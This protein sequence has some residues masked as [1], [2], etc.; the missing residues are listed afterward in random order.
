MKP[1]KTGI[2]HKIWQIRVTGGALY[3][4]VFFMLFLSMF[5]LSLL[6][7]FELSFREDAYFIKK[8]EL[9]DNIASAAAIVSCYPERVPIG[10]V[11]GIDVFEDETAIVAVTSE[12]WGLLRKMTFENT[13][14]SIRNRKI[15]LMA[16]KEKVRPALWMPDNM[17]YASL[18]GNSSIRGD[19]YISGMGLRTGNIEGRY[20]EG[21]VLNEGE[22]YVSEP[23]MPAFNNE[24]FSY[25]TQY[26]KG[27]IPSSDSLVNSNI[28]KR[29]KDLK[30]YFTE[31]TL[32]IQ[33]SGK[34][35]LDEGS[36]SGNIIICSGDTIEIFPSIR[37][38]NVILMG[39]IIILHEGVNGKFQAFASKSIEVRK[40]CRLE[41]P[42]FLGVL[43]IEPGIEL[44][45]DENCIINGGVLCHSNA[46]DEEA[47]VLSIG[48]GSIIYGKAYVNGDLYLSGDIAGSLYCNRFAYKTFRAF[49]EN[50]ILDC[51][52][53]SEKL[54]K[55]YASFTF[56]DDV[57]KLREIQICL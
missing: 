55:D 12:R 29:E 18:V 46:Q 21:S 34:L 32:L 15:V 38:D 41:Y 9:D 56:T 42:S 23:E 31:K 47:A 53:D 14:R 50:F 49:Y 54:P 43:D 16:E 45:I 44:S 11:T 20:F 24:L 17:R 39:K 25:F 40:N 10:S 30:H 4:A 19:C 48:K 33:P 28:L 3:Y 6:L 13:W 37:L 52:I 1:Q 36:L 26:F 7:F 5:S 2:P 27:Y 22:I 51:T 35:L 8:T 57:D